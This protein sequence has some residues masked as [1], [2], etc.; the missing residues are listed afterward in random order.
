VRLEVPAASL[1]LRA[2]TEITGWAFTQFSG[3]VYWVKAGIVTKVPQGEQSYATVSAWLRRMKAVNGAGL[4]KPV[5]DAVKAGSKRS[6]P[7]KKLLRDYFVEH[8]SA[9]T[10]PT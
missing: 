7:Q 3:T 6:D 4:P 1:R 2:G 10:R 9:A 5:Q 8:A